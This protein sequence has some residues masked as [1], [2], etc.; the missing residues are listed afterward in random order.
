MLEGLKDYEY[1][2]LSKVIKWQRI[3][4]E[5]PSFLFKL[6]DELLNEDKI[7]ALP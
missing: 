1:P 3:F 6:C 2:V 7:Y 5:D 4:A